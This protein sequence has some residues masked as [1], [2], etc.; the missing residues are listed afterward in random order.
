MQQEFKLLPVRDLAIEYGTCQGAT[1]DFRSLVEN[2]S[3]QRRDAF[4]ILR[5][6]DSHEMVA[7]VRLRVR[8][9]GGQD[10]VQEVGF[11]S[12]LASFLPPGFGFCPRDIVALLAA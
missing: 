5:L 9:I 6:D 1:I 11:F 3:V 4:W 12:H 2:S 7:D 8:G 10:M